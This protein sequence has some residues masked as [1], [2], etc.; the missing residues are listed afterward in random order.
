MFARMSPDPQRGAKAG[1]PAQKYLTA[2]EIIPVA[3]APELL[4]G[5]RI[6]QDSYE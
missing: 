3:R 6:A 4:K 1:R 5:Y 2:T